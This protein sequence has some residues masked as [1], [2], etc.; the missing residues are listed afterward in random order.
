VVGIGA[1]AGGLNALKRLFEHVPPNSNLA[2]VVVVHLS[3][4]HKSYLPDLLQA[5]VRFPVRQVTETTLLE[6]NNVYVIPPNA[7]ISAI[8]T[9]LRLSKLEERRGRAPIDHFFRTLARVHDGNSI[10]VILTGTGSDGTLGLKEIKA[11]GGLVVVQ[12]PNEAEFDGMPQSAIA[13]GLV[14]RVLPIAQIPETLLRYIRTDPRVTVPGDGKED[15][16]HSER[17]LLPKVLAVLKTRTERDFSR[18]KSAT[19][20]RR[21]ARRM[22]LNY[23]EDANHYLERLRENPEEAS[24][25]ADDLLITVTSFF[26]DAEVFKR[27]E[28]DVIPKLLEGKGPDDHLRVW[29]V[30]CATGEEAYSLAMLLMEASS[31]MEAPPQIQVFASDLHKRSLDSARDGIYSGDIEADVSPE[32][33]K[34]FF[35]AENGGYRVRKEVREL[36]VFAPHNLLGDPPFSRIHLISCRNLLIYLN[37]SVQQDVIDLFHYALH[38][39]GYLLLGSSESVE[40]PELFKTEDKKICLFR[41]RNVPGPEPNLPVFPLARYSREGYA[42]TYQ[43]HSPATAPYEVL[44]QSMLERYAPPSILVGPDDKVL[45]LS[46]HAGKY[47]VHPG[48]TVTSSIVKLVREELRIELRSLLQHA[49]GK[50]EPVDSRAVPVRFNGHPIPVVIH[51]RPAQDAEKE[52]YV[53]VIFDERPESAED[54]LATPGLPASSGQEAKRIS[55]LESELGVAHHRMQAIIEEYETSREEMRAANEEMQSSNEELRSTM[56]EL[57]TS[58]EELQSIN[59]ELQTVN[60][61]NRHKVEELSQ[62]SSD[63]QNLLVAT[64]IATL[65]LDRDLRIMRFTPR[66]A[67]LFNVRVTDRGRPIS[68]LTHRLGYEQ[69]RQDAEAVLSRLVPIERE[70]EDDRGHWYLA[71]VLPYRS[72][73]DRIEGI[74]LTF[75][76]ITA[77]KKAEEAIRASARELFDKGAWL[78]TVLDSL[79]DGII[80]IDARA[81][82]SY[83]NPVAERLTEWQQADALNKPIREVY[84]LRTMTGQPVAASQLQQALSARFNTGK[85]RFLLRS[86]GGQMTPIEDSAAPIL[87]AGQVEGAVMI[88]EEITGRLREEKLQEDE[89]ERLEGEI[90]QASDQLGQTRAELSALSA[91]LINALEQERKRL[92]RELHDDFGQRVSVLQMRANR[93]I[94]QLEKDPA[95]AE[96]ILH[97]ISAEVTLLNLGLREVSHRLHPAVLEDLGLIAALRSL[98]A[99][100]QDDGMDVSFNLPG[101][102]AEVTPEAATAL[103]RIAQEAIRN[104]LKHAPGAP[105]H[106]SLEKLNG[107][108]QLAIRDGGQG[109]DLG[110]VRLSGGLGILNMN[111]RARLVNGSLDLKSHPGDGTVVT[112]RVPV[113]APQ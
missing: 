24:A 28:K 1:S 67:E 89:R 26:R 61:E 19:I 77:Q 18:Y 7:N 93:A 38:P 44:H 94:E 69:L 34:R 65:F 109:F 82:I 111:E 54:A 102:M 70:I 81:Q 16:P 63:L 57:E 80:A 47:L 8:D 11:R 100:F 21:I 17:I 39:D 110:K 71:R 105:V 27:L 60:Q 3:P 31:R 66:V 79:S 55:Q 86:R 74:V 42:V 99:G 64:A 87:A 25:L 98:I 29:S 6:A 53:L 33:L 113:E 78:R 48:G 73:D 108:I 104:A 40:S 41:K 37:R 91:Y 84:D 46:E 92:A 22:Q 12:D 103:Y 15:T 72:T 36:V 13:T 5:T 112:V 50:R 83:L 76:D 95:E 59:E 68:D 45:H 56:E 4:D 23:L 51:V 62:L 2:F 43:V 32:R 58:K 30:G 75:I 14:D 101:E 10:G 107:S 20:L 96:A 9:H 52:G 90:H 88:V 97:S 106:V 85:E 35:Q 49:R